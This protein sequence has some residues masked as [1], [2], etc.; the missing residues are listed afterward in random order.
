MKKA[1]ISRRRFS[2]RLLGQPIAEVK[3]FFYLVSF[4]PVFQGFFGVMFSFAEWMFL[5]A[6]RFAH[7]FE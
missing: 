6:N 4:V 2:G 5:T 3:V 7:G 1:A